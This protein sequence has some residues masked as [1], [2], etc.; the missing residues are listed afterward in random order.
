VALA[1]AA[2]AFAAP[3]CAQPTEQQVK[4]AMIYN[5]ARF[6]DWPAS[7][8]SPA[9]VTLCILG[10][11]P[12]G[13]DIDGLVGQPIGA[14]PLQVRRIA[15]AGAMNGCQMVY[16]SPSE[17]DDLEGA[18]A[19]LS[20]AHVFT[21]ADT[22]G[23]AERGVAANLYLDERHVRFEI[24]IDAARRTGLGVSSHLLRLARLTHDKAAA[25]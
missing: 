23:F 3:A 20:G 10:R 2:I 22:D 11:D 19:V 13:A 1:A 14:A 4:A 18:L 21:V 17:A 16:I 15:A 8:G 7:P 25:R 24:N 9:R 12:F 6:I 5:I